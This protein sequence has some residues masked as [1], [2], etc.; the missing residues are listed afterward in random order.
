MERLSQR[1]GGCLCEF[2]LESV[3]NQPLIF[4]IIRNLTET[5]S[6]LSVS[7]ETNWRLPLWGF[8]SERLEFAYI[9]ERGVSLE[10]KSLG[11]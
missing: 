8:G 10:F 2:R 6:K 7:S 4:S 5:N 1:E 11:F 3:G 9:Y